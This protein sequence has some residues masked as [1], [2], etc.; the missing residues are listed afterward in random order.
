MSRWLWC[1]LDPDTVLALKAYFQRVDEVLTATQFGQRLARRHPA[2][3]ASS[4]EQNQRLPA[5]PILSFE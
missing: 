1:D 2:V 5:R 3:R 4:S